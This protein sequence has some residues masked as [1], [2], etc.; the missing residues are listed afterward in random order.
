M[1]RIPVFL[2]SPIAD[3]GMAKLGCWHSHSDKLQDVASL[4]KIAGNSG[5]DFFGAPPIT[6]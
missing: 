5:S 3:I 4:A 6:P 2:W 1:K